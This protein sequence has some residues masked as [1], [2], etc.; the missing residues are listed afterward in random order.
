MAATK[1]LEALDQQL[2]SLQERHLDA[3]HALI[4]S[5]YR[6]R[7]LSETI[8]LIGSL[9]T[10]LRS[11]ATLGEVSPKTRD[12]ILSFGERLTAPIFA[13]ALAAAGQPSRPIDARTII[14]TDS[15]FGHAVVDWAASGSKFASQSFGADVPVFTGYIAADADGNTTTLGRGGSDYTASILGALAHSPQIQIWT[16]VEGML[17]ADPSMVPS[18]KTIAQI[19][20]EEAAELSFYGAK[21]IYPPSILP[22]V[23]HGI[24]IKIASTF[25]PAGQHTIISRR[26]NGDAL[27]VKG[28]SAIKNVSLFNISGS[29]LVGVPGVSGR[30]FRSLAERQISVSFISQASSEHSICFAIDPHQTTAALACI[31]TTFAPEIAAGFVDPVAVNEQVALVAVV[32]NGLKHQP[33]VAGK[34]FT[35]LGHNGIN[36]IAAAQGASEINFTIA[37]TTADLQKAIL[38]LH[39]SLFLSDFKQLNLFLAGP[40]LI[41]RTLL[42]QIEDQRADLLR[43]LGVHIHVAGLANSSKMALATDKSLAL[44]DLHESNTSSTIE[45]FAAAVAAANL[46]NSI[47]VDCSAGPAV[48]VVYQP[49]LAKSI[50]IVTPN[51]TSVASPLANYQAIKATA[52]LHNAKFLYETTAGAGLPVIRTIQDLL[53]SG[54]SITRIE[55][56]LSGTLSFLFNGMAQGSSFSAALGQAIA[57]GYTEPDPRDD[58]SGLD[59]ARKVLIL[60]RE[61]GAKLDLADL[62]VQP[63]LPDAFTATRMPLAEFMARYAELDATFPQAGAGNHL[64]FAGLITPTEAKVDILE[65]DASH[66]FYALSGADNIVS[67]TSKRYSANPLII[68]GPGAG[69]QVTA[70]GIFAEIISLAN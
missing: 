55:A 65:I 64:C 38:A 24:P 48:P 16:D 30:L 63:L 4:P 22:A 62:P 36:V 44:T 2:A 52:K 53:N 14:A 3:I 54:D 23:Q 68:R 5:Q 31:A 17:S 8:Y 47:F 35:A 33:G 20:Y 70:A 40:G 25:A 61:M 41:G 10:I 57:L 32:G 21:V 19:S 27:G 1:Q 6:A 69:A 66:P 11:A 39:Q 56:I 60:A 51:K 58:L 43:N 49:L 42:Q 18:A 29:G 13:A 46:P 28:I 50:S 37:I 34:I 9:G 12:E 59:M 15:S 7:S 45:A 26:Q 67:I